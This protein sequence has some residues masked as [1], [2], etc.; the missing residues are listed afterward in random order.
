MIIAIKQLIQVMVFIIVKV[1]K[2]QSILLHRAQKKWVI[3]ALDVED[4]CSLKVIFLKV[5]LKA[6]LIYFF[7]RSVSF[8]SRSNA[9]A[10]IIFQ[11]SRFFV[12]EVFLESVA[13]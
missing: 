7:L 4:T 8:F 10:F 6:S 3:Y 5:P 9:F 1:K 12:L 11:A 2:V 13:F